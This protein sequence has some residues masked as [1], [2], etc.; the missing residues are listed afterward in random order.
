MNK[1]KYG[2]PE[3]DEYVQE[4]RE[5]LEGE[6]G[7]VYDTDEVQKK[8]EVKGFRAPYCVAVDKETNKDV[9]LAFQHSP[10]FYWVI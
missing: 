3:W 9:V 6:H 4:E 10:R 1:P 7:K 2:T 5:R 8:F